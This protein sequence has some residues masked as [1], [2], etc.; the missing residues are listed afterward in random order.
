MKEGDIVVHKLTKEKVIIIRDDKSFT[1]PIRVRLRDYS[2]LDV[3]PF[4]LE[5]RK[6]EK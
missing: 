5:E 6:E 1:L 3:Y 4:E 2:T